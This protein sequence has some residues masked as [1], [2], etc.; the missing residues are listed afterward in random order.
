ME[1]QHF[2]VTLPLLQTSAKSAPQPCY[3]VVRRR[4]RYAA[5]SRRAERRARSDE[6]RTSS[7]AAYGMETH[8]KLSIRRHNPKHKFSA[9]QPAIRDEDVAHHPVPARSFGHLARPRTGSRITLRRSLT[10]VGWVATILTI[11]GIL[12]AML[13]MAIAVSV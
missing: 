7:G 5:R 12:T 2:D 8:R 9:A 3:A 13:I 6:A 11:V 4:N 10:S 1:T